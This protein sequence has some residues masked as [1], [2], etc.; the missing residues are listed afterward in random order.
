MKSAPLWTALYF[1]DADRC[2]HVK[3][4]HRKGQPITGKTAMKLA[5]LYLKNNP[6]KVSRLEIVLPGGPGKHGW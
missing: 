5:R 1:N 6:H 4:G 3:F 2:Y